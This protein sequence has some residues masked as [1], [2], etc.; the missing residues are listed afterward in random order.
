MQRLSPHVRVVILLT[1]LAVS[2]S[3][4]GAA[5]EKPLRRFHDPVIVKTSELLSL[6]DHQTRSYRLY[7]SLSG[8]WMPIPYQFDQR[9]ERRDIVFP[10]ATDSS[11]CHERVGHL[12]LD[13]RVSAR[14]QSRGAR[15]L[16]RVLGHEDELVVAVE[17]RNVLL[18]D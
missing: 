14:R 9:Y 5:S 10:E 11:D 13:P 18:D 4:R 6:E 2:P 16:A 8:S 17:R 12:D 15:T 1:L 7:A 3:A